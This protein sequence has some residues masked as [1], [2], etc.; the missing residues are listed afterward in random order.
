MVGGWLLLLGKAKGRQNAA[1]GTG[2]RNRLI[3][4]TLPDARQVELE[5]DYGTLS[6]DLTSCDPFLFLPWTIDEHLPL[7]RINE[8]AQLR[9]VRHPV[10]QLTL[11]FLKGVGFRQKLNH[12]IRT[13]VRETPQVTFG[14]LL[15]AFL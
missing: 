9:A 12:K 11:E 8:P 1:L 14:Q 4:V 10:P 13:D 2:I 15:Q 5:T 6:A 7:I 3:L